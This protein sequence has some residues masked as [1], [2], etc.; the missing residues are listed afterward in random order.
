[1]ATSAVKMQKSLFLL[2]LTTAVGLL[3]PLGGCSPEVDPALETNTTASDTTSKPQPDRT[4]ALLPSFAHIVTEAKPAVVNI[5]TTQTVK[6]PTTPPFLGPSPF[7]GESPFEEFFRHFFP[8][9][10]RT[11]KRQSLGSGFVIDSRGII[12]TNHHV[13]DQA[14]EIIIRLEEEEFKAKVLGSDPATDLAVLKIKT[15]RTLPTLSF[16]NSDQLQVGDWVIAIGNPFGLSQ[17]VTAG[18][19]SAT[20][21]VIGQGPYDDFIQTDASINPGNSGGPLLNARGE[22]IGI[23]TAIFSQTGGNIGIGFATPSNLARD[24]A[25]KLQAKGKI[26]RGWLG[27]TIQ[28]LDEDLAK[29]FGL[30]EKQGALVADVEKGSPAD[31]AGIRRG[32]VIMSFHGKPLKSIQD[33][34]REVATADPGTKTEIEIIR[35]DKRQ[36]LTAKIGEQP[37]KGRGEQKEEKSADNK[38][39]LFIA[40]LTPDVAREL[41]IPVDS[42]VL[43]QGV[44]AGSPADKAGLQGG[45]VI[46]EV[47]RKA[48]SSVEE[49]RELIQKTKGSLLVLIQRGSSTFFTTLKRG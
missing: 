48:V 21:R 17:T 1:M 31:K 13:V 30:S 43:V 2:Y 19:V 37:S 49:L 3:A 23:N 42:G 7:G 47:N 44:Q 4:A 9:T 22:V 14:E 40:P 34:S 45:D 11:F 27:V 33:L 25:K 39:G 26:V 10:P 24:I 46:L 6:T 16:G 28:E 15:S 18:I 5:A 12:V 41:G 35:K 29:A 32:D 8:D 38:L 20:G 36:T